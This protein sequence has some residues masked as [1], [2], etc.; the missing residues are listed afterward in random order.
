MRALNRSRKIILA[1]ALVILVTAFVFILV[2]LQEIQQ[3]ALIASDRRKWVIHLGTDL[4]LVLLLAAIIVIWNWSLR[5]QVQQKT[6]DL[7]KEL[8]ERKQTEEALRKERDFAESLLN[9]AQVII[10]VLDV[11]GRIVR[12]NPYME[13]ISGYTLAQVQGKDWFN[14]FL[15]VE[16]QSRVRDLFR[17]AI[18]NIQTKG[19]VNPIVRKDGSEREIEWHD[20]TLKDA[21]GNVVGLLAVGMDITE[22]KWAEEGQRKALADA[23]QATHALRE[24]EQ[25]YRSLIDD[26]VDN[27][28]IGVFIL[29]SDFRVTWVNRT[30]ERYFGLQ[31]EDV[32]GK[33]KRQLIREQIK[34]TFED[35]ETFAKTVLATYDNNTYTENFECHALS[36][37][38]REERWLEHW[39]HPIQ[40]GRYTGGRV[41]LYYDITERKRAEKALHRRTAQLE[42]LHE[43]G[44]EIAAQLDLDALLHSIALRTS[45]LLGVSIG[46]IVLYRSEQNVLELVVTTDDAPIPTGTTF[47]LDEGFTGKIWETGEALIVGNYRRWEGRTSI[48]DDLPDVAVAGAPIRWGQ[49][50]RKGELEGILIAADSVSHV[51]S[52]AD[53]GLLDMLATQAAIAIENAQLYEQTRQDAETRSV[54]LREVN[55][56]VKNNLTGILG[57]LYT[58]RDRVEIDVDKV[59]PYVDTVH[60]YATYR[61]TMDDLICRVRGLATAHDLL[62]ASRWKPLLLSDLATRII[63]VSLEAL[64]HDKHI[65]VNV[66][67]SSVRVTSDQAHNLALVIGE[68]TTNTVKYALEGRDT[69]QITFQSTLND[70]SDTI[71]PRVDRQRPLVCCE[72]RD[73]GPGYPQD[74]LRMEHRSVGFDLMQNIMRQGLRGGLT[75]HNERGA[76]AVIRFEA[77]VWEQ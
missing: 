58:A 64:P 34:Y 7:S 69:A 21:D 19:N 26:V 57:L 60:P 56:R 74:V 33:D 51:F 37:D 32:V 76:V 14:T 44:L 22:R 55:H 23:L 8:A 54:L 52:Q 2:R 67:P 15:P 12:F 65:V 39:S 36:G 1:H 70:D 49:A 53:V 28:E 77:Q 68:L 24:S 41:E 4:G 45:E 29:D 48:F 31:R 11:D 59:H 27:A 72:F 9:T 42:A 66:L 43:V 6:T 40:S 13:E 3:D 47:P 46:G 62:S 20:K 38:E 10:L 16:D 63:N 5:R 73:D 17:K 71:H 25:R 50:D 30:L 75:L 61:S 18:S 35:P